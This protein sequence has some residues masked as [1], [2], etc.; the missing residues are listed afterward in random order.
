MM[1]GHQHRFDAA[2]RRHPVERRQMR[3]DIAPRPDSVSVCAVV[4]GRG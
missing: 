1:A 2:A 4:P 3:L